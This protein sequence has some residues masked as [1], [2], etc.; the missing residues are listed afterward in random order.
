MIDVIET[1]RRSFLKSATVVGGALVLEF[2]LPALGPALGGPAG[3]AQAAAAATA[4]NSFVRIGPDGAVTMTVGQAEMGQGVYSGFAQIL[5]DELGADWSRV[6]VVSADPHSDHN[7]PWFG[8]QMTGGSMSI[9]AHYD[10][11]RKAAATARE[12]LVQ[13]AAEAWGISA[14]GLST[15]AGYVIDAAGNR[16]VGFG[17]IAAAAARMAPPA[18]PRLKDPDAFTLIGRRVDRPDL[19][20]KVEGSAVFGV[21]VFVPGMAYAAVR[22]APVKGATVAS[23]DRASIEGMP[24]VIDVVQVPGGIAVVADRWWRAKQAVDALAVTFAETPHD[25]ATTAALMDDLR[26]AFEAP[27]AALAEA[28]GDAEAALAGAA[29]LVEADYDAPLLAHATM[30][31]MNCT[32]SVG[33]GS[34]E[35]WAPNQAPGVAAAAAAKVTGLDPS[36]VTVR[37]TFLGGGFG[38][39]FEPDFVVQAV[40]ASKAVGRPVKLIWTR[41]E[42]MQHDFYRPAAVARFRAGLDADG[43]ILGWTTRISAPS[44]MQHV[45]PDAIRNGVDPSNVEGAVEL[46]YAFPARRV[47]YVMGKTHLDI[48]FWRSVGHSHNGFFTEAFLDEVAVAAKVDPY[49]FRRRL[50]AH[51]ARALKVLD[52]A[53]E[54]GDWDAPLPQGRGRGIAFHESFGSLVAQVAEV[55]VENGTVRV[56]RVACAVDC[57]LAVNPDS[58]EAQMESAIVYGLTAALRGEITVEGGKVQQGNFHDYELLRM[59]EMPAVDTVIIEGGPPV[60]GIGEPGTP[61]I[62]AAVTNAIFAATGKRIRSLPIRNQNLAV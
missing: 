22:N 16:R 57:G 1:S 62:A 51:D 56:H 42:D 4:I 55:S 35:V 43:K 44:V 24:G 13:A 19:P 17:E 20:A 9:R 34:C 15:E 2:A 29:T 33:N 37:T 23:V 47:D 32:A 52:A 12:M 27:D 21:D 50:L 46:R 45:F 26:A 8:M 54:K 58:I 7:N 41:E 40:T 36:Q 48:G 25:G 59:D 61:P 39:R 53:A 11:L 28:D 6:S 3:R 30:E 60:G 18:E 10:V 49:Q 14:D 31:P 5:A 38:R